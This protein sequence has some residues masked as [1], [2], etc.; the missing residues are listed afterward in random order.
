MV[1]WQY[2]ACV[3]VQWCDYIAWTHL[4]ESADA[5]RRPG[6]G[7]SHPDAGKHAQRVYFAAP[8]AVALED[9]S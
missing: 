1:V 3:E 9:F 4:K 7:S 2:A 5:E 8:T 6:G